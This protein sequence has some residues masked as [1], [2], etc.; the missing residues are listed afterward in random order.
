MALQ[1]S[2]NAVV[3]TS[4]VAA[5]LIV[6]SFAT[7]LPTVQFGT[8]ITGILLAALIGDSILLFVLMMTKLGQKIIKQS[9]EQAGR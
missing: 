5:T 6:L 2:G 4:L 8:L 3:R 1:H 9:F 7:F